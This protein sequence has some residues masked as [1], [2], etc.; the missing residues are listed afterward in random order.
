M[1]AIFVTATGTDVGKT[2]VT[3]ALIKAAKRNGRAV[4]A[5]KPVISGFS[6]AAAAASD[7]AGEY[8]RHWTGRATWPRS[9]RFHRGV[10]QQ[11]FR[12]R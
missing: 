4:S 2:Y 9:S 1:A 10:I 7:T 3:C 11:L 12:W 8:S 5:Y 6:E